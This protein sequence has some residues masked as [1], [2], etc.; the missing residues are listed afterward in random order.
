M[1]YNHTNK[2]ELTCDN[3][4][5]YIQ[6]LYFIF[7]A[8]IYNGLPHNVHLHGY[9]FDVLKMGYATY[10]N[11]TGFYVEKNADIDCF[12]DYCSRPQWRNSSWKGGHV[13][14]TVSKP[15]QKDTLLIPVGG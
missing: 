6:N 1:C 8:A 13:P 2:C 14:N 5:V 4:Y 9:K 11:R 7:T 12:K 10:D 3:K 15:V